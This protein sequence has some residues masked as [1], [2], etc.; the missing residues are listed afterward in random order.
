VQPLSLFQI[1]T[2]LQ[3]AD[4]PEAAGILDAIDK[5][6]LLAEAIKTPF[7]LNTVQLLFARSLVWENFGF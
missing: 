7:Y 1:R 2:G 4:S 6:E 5:N 3:E